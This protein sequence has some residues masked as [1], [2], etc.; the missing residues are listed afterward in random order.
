VKLISFGKMQW[1]FP[2]A[3]TLHNGEEAICMPQWISAHSGLLPLHP[4]RGSIWVGLLLL[5]LAAFAVTILSA[6]KGEQS[7]WAYLL[8]GYVAAMFI[9]VF[10]P[11]IPA[12]LVYGEYTPGVVTAG[13]INFPIMSILLFK[14]VRDQWVSG[15]KA[16][17]YALLVPLTIGGSILA[18]FALT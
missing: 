1:L 12:T 18:L 9:N 13:L 5:T 7:T 11:H 6:Q 15:I 3:V 8:F 14:A 10:L 2:I 4:G 16:I 17:G